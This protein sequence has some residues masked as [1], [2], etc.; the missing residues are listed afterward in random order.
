M[1]ATERSLCAVLEIEKGL[2]S[3]ENLGTIRTPPRCAF[4]GVLA[5]GFALCAANRAGLDALAE[6]GIVEGSARANLHRAIAV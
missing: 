5:A 2:N 4:L 6:G 1:L 3:A